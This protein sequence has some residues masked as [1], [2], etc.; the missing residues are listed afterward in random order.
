MKEKGIGYDTVAEASGL[1]RATLKAWR[2][3]SAPT[4]ATIEAAYNAVGWQFLPCPKLETLPDDIAADLARLAAKMQADVPIVFSTL[5]TLAADQTFLRER[6]KERIEARE[7][8]RDAQRCK[9]NR[10]RRKPETH[11]NDNLRQADENIA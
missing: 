4:Y 8:E 3:R 2:R 6:A 9:R 10:S 1:L 11:A 5:L 7:A